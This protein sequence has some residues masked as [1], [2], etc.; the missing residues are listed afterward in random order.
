MKQPTLIWEE[1]ESNLNRA[2]VQGGWIVQQY[3][4]FYDNARD[5]MDSRLVST[6]FIPDENHVWL[7]DAR[8]AEPTCSTCDG[9]GAIDSGGVTPW[10]AGIDIAC[11]EC[12][13]RRNKANLP[14]EPTS[15]TCRWKP[16]E[17]A[18][19]DGTHILVCIAG[20]ERSAGEAFYVDNNWVTWD[21]ENHTRT[22]YIEKPTHWMPLHQPPTC[23]DKAEPTSETC[24]CGMLWPT[25]YCP[26]CGLLAR[27][28]CGKKIEVVE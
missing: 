25:K 22:V 12:E 28:T 14:T 9:S 4:Q 16:I 11:P 10:G 24:K 3:E 7:Q 19:L 6:F 13:A 17:T 20:L 18:P 26:N 5:R 1:V 15:E 2:S 21:G 8:P 27:H 23:S